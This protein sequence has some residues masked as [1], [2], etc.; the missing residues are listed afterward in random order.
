MID[1]MFKFKIQN[2]DLDWLFE[3]EYDFKWK[4][5]FDYKV[6]DL[7]EGYNFHMQFIFIRVLKN[8][9]LK[10]YRLYHRLK[11]WSRVLKYF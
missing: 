4:K 10:M 5:M 2:L 7:N 6:V 3:P 8:D 9:F 1:I 11:W